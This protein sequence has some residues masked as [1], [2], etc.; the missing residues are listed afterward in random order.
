VSLIHHR[1]LHVSVLAALFAFA[2]VLPVWADDDTK[3]ETQNSDVIDCEDRDNATLSECQTVASPDAAPADMSG[4]DEGQWSAAP[5]APPQPTG[6]VI[7]NGSPVDILFTLADAGK[8]ATPYKFEEGSDARS[9]WARARYERRSDTGSQDTLGPRV[10]DH[11]VYVTQNFEQAKQLF[12]EEVA[13]NE[14]FPEQAARDARKGS[15]KWDLV[16]LVEQTGALSACNDC[17]GKDQLMLHH[18]I[19]QQR[20]NI[21][22]VIYLYGREGRGSEQITSQKASELWPRK[23]S[24]RI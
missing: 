4:G 15:F 10:I 21:V 6:P 13:K 3:R 20:Y 2:L 17:G 22:S 12:T 23:V 9:R 24:E 7:F 11:T 18:R 16:N 5:S 1:S 8:E 19:V 14:K